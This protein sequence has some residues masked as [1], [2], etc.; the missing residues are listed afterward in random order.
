MHKSRA[1]R[2]VFCDDF[3]PSYLD[4]VR[5]HRGRRTT[6]QLDNGL[7]RFCNWL[8]GKGVSDPQS[9][10]AV[11]VRDF[12]SSLGRFRPATIA[13]HASA[14]RGFLEYL[15]LKGA[16]NAD[17]S[18]AVEHPR[19][20]RWSQPPAVLDSQTVEHILGSLDRSTPF[21]KRDYAILLLAALSRCGHRF[22]GLH[23]RRTTSL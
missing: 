13:V 19:L 10:T 18:Y 22:G 6:H 5:Q 11:H 14:L 20:Y 21:G 9:L 4:F 12:I 16:L 8:A 15:H 7:N 2:L 23:P 1:D 3:V 17:L